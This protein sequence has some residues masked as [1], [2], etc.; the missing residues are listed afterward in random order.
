MF[1]R[2]SIGIT[3]VNK[4]SFFKIEGLHRDPDGTN[5]DPDCDPVASKIKSIGPWPLPTPPKI[6]SKSI[7]NF[8]CDLA[9]RQTDRQMLKQDVLPSLEVIS[10]RRHI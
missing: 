9:D 10:F 6:S 7:H 2:L 4:E 1:Y 5:L 3:V 8:L